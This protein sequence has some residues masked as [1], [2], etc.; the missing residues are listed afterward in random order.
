LV[1]ERGEDVLSGDA[2]DSETVGGVSL[3]DVEGSVLGR[4]EV[5][6]DLW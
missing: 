5:D 2:G 4:G 1:D 6:A 3:P